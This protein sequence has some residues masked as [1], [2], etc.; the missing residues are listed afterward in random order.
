MIDEPKDQLIEPKFWK[1]FVI[2]IIERDE[3][4][5]KSFVGKIN[6]DLKKLIVIIQTIKKSN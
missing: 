3:H 2:K 5:R 1:L 4:V 6:E